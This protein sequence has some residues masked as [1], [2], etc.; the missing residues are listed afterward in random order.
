MTRKSNTDVWGT[1]SCRMMRG[2]EATVRIHLR[3]RTEAPRGV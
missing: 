2:A 3:V 1:E